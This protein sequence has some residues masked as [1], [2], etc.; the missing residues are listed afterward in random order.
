MQR[1]VAEGTA[2]VRYESW[3]NMPQEAGWVYGE[4]INP[5]K[6]TQRNLP[7][8]DRRPASA[9]NKDHNP[10]LRPLCPGPPRSWQQTL[11]DEANSGPAVSTVFGC[12]ELDLRQ[13][14]K[15]ESLRARLDEA[16]GRHDCDLG[17]SAVL[18]GA[19]LQSPK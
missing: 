8:W 15:G 12:L 16:V 3:M 1:C 19:V 18:N 9:R 11:G 10:R 2:A 17:P 14:L 7:L 6:K 13:R 5:E 4:T